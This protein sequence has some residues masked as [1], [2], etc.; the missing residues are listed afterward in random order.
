MQLLVILNL[1][2]LALL[3]CAIPARADEESM[4]AGSGNCVGSALV[5]G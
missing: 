2:S 4:W 5:T 3:L 1:L